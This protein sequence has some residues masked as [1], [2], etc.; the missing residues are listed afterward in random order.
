[1]KRILAIAALMTAAFGA[2]Q[3]ADQT[4]KTSDGQAFSLNN[5]YRIDRVFNGEY[6]RVTYVN[7]SNTQ[8]A[9]NGSVYNKI[10]QNNPHLIPIS[11]TAQSLVNPEYATRIVCQSGISRIAIQGTG[12]IVEAADSCTMA[13]LAIAKAK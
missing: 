3:A 4:Y 1:M 13:N 8:Y 9:D 2:A 5:V 12:T 10:L 11:G 6:L 7:G